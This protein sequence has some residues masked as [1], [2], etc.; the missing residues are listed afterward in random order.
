ML[1]GFLNFL[2]MRLRGGHFERTEPTWC[3]LLLCRE[4]IASVRARWPFA[5]QGSLGGGQPTHPRWGAAD[6]ALLPSL[7]LRLPRRPAACRAHRE[8][9]D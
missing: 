5:A 6:E 4:D 8:G 1:P 2:A 9:D 7:R 3:G